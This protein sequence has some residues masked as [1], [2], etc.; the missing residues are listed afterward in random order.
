MASLKRLERAPL[1]HKGV[2]DAL[3]DFIVRSALEPGDAL[4]SEGEL[5]RQLGVSRT[6]VREAVKALETIGLLESRR[7]S[8]VYVATFSFDPLLESL[9]YGL[10]KDSRAIEELLDVRCTLEV[11]LADNMIARRSPE[12]LAD[13]TTNLE[14]FRAAA[15]AGEPLHGPDRE[16]HKL[17]ARNLDNRVFIGLIDVFWRTYH[18][19][20]TSIDLV[21]VD[22][23][24]TYRDH[25]GIYDAFARGDAPAM[26]AMIDTHFHGIRAL[27]AHQR[28]GDTS[29][30][31]D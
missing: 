5:A 2:Q 13:L 11:A 3:K 4:P 15:E 28:G 24:A 26:K 18:R 19:A 10:M 27:L 23:V 7:G 20:A 8:G 29:T 12:Q 25:V 6:S 1:L 31:P 21:N 17:L 9:P 30:T 16:F 22:P 14:V